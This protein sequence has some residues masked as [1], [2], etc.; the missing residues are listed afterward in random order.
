P[1]DIGEMTVD[2]FKMNPRTLPSK[3][4]MRPSQPSKK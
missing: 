2:L 3:V 1:E 4:E